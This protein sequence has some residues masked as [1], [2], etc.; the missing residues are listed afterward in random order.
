MNFSRQGVVMERSV[1][2]DFVFAE[3]MAHFG[4]ISKKALN[5]YHEC[6]RMT[7]PLLMRPHLVV[8]LDVPVDVTLK[9]IQARGLPQEINSSVLSA[10]FLSQMELQYKQKFLR[11]MNNHAQILVY[12]WSEE[13]D[14]EVVVEDIE[15]VNFEFDRNDPKMADW[16]LQDEW[17]WCGKRM[18]YTK[19]RHYFMKWLTVP[20]F[21]VEEL[22]IPAGDHKQ[23][24][25]VLLSAPGEKYEVGFN[26]DM[27]DQFILTKVKKDVAV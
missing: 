18:E 19:Y 12:D 10:E 21:S 26:A 2:S 3:T 27:G 20:D 11:E 9:K 25:D 14:P 15:R 6:R 23:Y 1:Y 16:K 7:V 22:I 24:M 8:Y 4:Y 5:L 17:A 13:G